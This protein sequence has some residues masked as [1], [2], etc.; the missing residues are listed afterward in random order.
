M[1]ASTVTTQSSASVRRVLL[2]IG[3]VLTLVGCTNSKLLL[4]P[5]YNSLDNRIEKR[6]RAVVTLTREQNAS[7]KTISDDFHLWHRWYE[8][9][10]YAKLLADISKHLAD[11][12]ATQETV[13][14]W[15]ESA[16][17]ARNRL[18]LCSPTAESAEVMASLTDTQVDQINEELQSLDDDDDAFDDD[19]RGTEPHLRVRRYLSLMGFRMQPD[20]LDRLKAMF[21]ATRA[22]R[23]EGPD[24]RTVRDEWNQRFVSLLEARNAPDFERQ[25]HTY[26]EQRN[27][28]FGSL[29]RERV[30][31]MWREYTYKE[32]QLLS[33]S[34]R[35]HAS[36]W[37]G[38]L[39][40]TL[41]SM[42]R[43]YRQRNES[44]LLV[45]CNPLYRL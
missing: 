11:N 40:R 4:S 8:L 12:S 30:R 36:R 32:I 7:V 41:S 35:R 15:F 39:S 34:Q 43:D 19:D 14:G 33:D 27:D 42:S 44:K 23:S 3:L 37:L 29:R 17:E 21:E 22:V 24:W 1:N 16:T 25:L 26:L 13:D 6:V 5:L 9:P 28:A 20:Q 31:A 2:A 38:K 10:R 18:F 45:A